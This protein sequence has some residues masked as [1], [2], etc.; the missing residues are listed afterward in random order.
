[1]LQGI[2][3]VYLF[4]SMQVFQVIALLFS[5][6]GF[7]R[8]WVYIKNSKILTSAFILYVIYVFFGVVS[9]FFSPYGKVLAGL[10][11]VLAN[12]K[13]YF[14]LAAFLY[15]FKFVSPSKLLSNIQLPYILISIVFLF[16]QWVFP[17]AY[18]LITG[19]YKVP[20][21]LTGYIKYP[22]MSIFNHPS[23]FAAVSVFMALYNYSRWCSGEGRRTFFLFI[24]NVFLLIS[25]NQR[26]E[27]FCF[28]I[29]IYLLTLYKTPVNLRARSA[30]LGL[31]FILSLVGVFVVLFFDSF[32]REFYLWG[33]GMHASNIPRY[34]HYSGALEF[35][36]RFFPLGTGFGTWGGLGSLQYN[37]DA[38][39]SLGMNKHWW[40]STREAYIFDAF[41]PNILAETGWFGSLIFLANYFLIIFFLS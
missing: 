36:E 24:F 2:S 30:V 7:P 5:F 20:V 35:A 14:M 25:S 28:I 21:E 31:F 13:I 18:I 1:M 16:V 32:I 19:Y 17:S 12:F 29:S 39:Y 23:V 34:L 9:L 37:L 11:Q 3:V 38:Y 4:P 15:L 33:G 40:W 27:I 6:L 22:G 8:L 10:V 26:Q 41:L